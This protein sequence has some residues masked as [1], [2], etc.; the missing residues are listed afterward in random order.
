MYLHIGVKLGS[1]QH[2]ALFG[3][4]LMCICSERP[5]NWQSGARYCFLLSLPIE[6]C[7]MKTR[8]QPGVEKISPTF[9]NPLKM[10][11]PRTMKR[12]NIHQI[13]PVCSSLW[14]TITPAPS[15][16]YLFV[17]LCPGWRS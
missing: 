10:L 15:I 12:N 13:Q 14:T 7:F 17:V 4:L 8:Q 6:Q 2:T 9:K 1:W 16:P 3:K 5:L 11:H